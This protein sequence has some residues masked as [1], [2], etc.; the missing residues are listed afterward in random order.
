MSCDDEWG[1]NCG[2]SKIARHDK[3]SVSSCHPKSPMFKC[4]EWMGV[5]IRCVRDAL[6]EQVN[7]M[8]E[9]KLAHGCGVS[10][11]KRSMSPVQ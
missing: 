5:G 7:A 10:S 2:Q 11:I 4:Q 1:G 9:Q 8:D 3:D 6:F